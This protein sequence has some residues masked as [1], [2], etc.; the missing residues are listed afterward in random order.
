M[1]V[2]EP[3]YNQRGL[4]SSE[5]LVL[6]AQKTSSGYSVPAGAQRTHAIQEVRYNPKGQK[7]YQELGNGTITCYDYDLPTFRLRQICTRR[8]SYKYNC[9]QHHSGLKNPDILQR[10]N[11]TYDPVGNITEIYDEAYEPVYF[12]NQQVEQ[13]SRYEYDA[14]YR[15]VRAAGR[16]DGAAQGAPGQFEPPLHSVDLPVVTPGALRNY[17]EEYE[18]D[19]VGNIQNLRHSAGPN[20]SFTRY[21]AYAASSN[22]LERTWEGNKN[23][24]NSG[25]THKVTYYYDTHGNMLN[26][27]NLAPADNLRWDY[28][29]ILRALPLPASDW[30]Y[31]NYDSGK[32]RSRK[33]LKRQN[34][35]VA[36][37]IYLGGFELYRKTDALGSVVEEIETHHLFEGD[38]R[39]LLVEEVLRTDNP[40]LPTGP[41]YRYQYSNHLGSAYVELNEQMKIITFEEYHPYGTSAYQAKNSQVKTL[42]KRY[43]YTGKEGDDGTGFYYYGARYYA[44]WLGR[45]ISPDPTGIKA[46]INPLTFN[47]SNPVRYF[48]PT[49]M[50]NVEVT[51][52]SFRGQAGVQNADALIQQVFQTG[53]APKGGTT[54]PQTLDNLLESIKNT[55]R[56]SG[57][58]Q[59]SLSPDVAIGFASKGGTKGGVVFEI[60]PRPDSVNVNTSPI[61]GVNPYPDQYIVAHPGGIE[62]GQVVRAYKVRAHKLAKGR[63]NILITE[64]TE[65]PNSILRTSSLPPA[66]PARSAPNSE[67]ILAAPGAPGVPHSQSGGVTR[68][69]NTVTS[70]IE[71]AANAF[72]PVAAET[73][74]VSKLTRFKAAAGSLLRSTASVASEGAEIVGK[75]AFVVG[76]YNE[77]ATTYKSVPGTWFDKGVAA[78]FTF[79]VPGLGGGIVDDATVALTGGVMIGPQGESYDQHGSGMAQHMLGE[80]QR[81]L[82]NWL[83]Q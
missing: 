30:A 3:T 57:F 58:V 62:P 70:T 8:P 2:Y 27:E 20:G 74:E 78:T 16:E 25:A 33:R 4:L 39:V 80:M 22:R 1:A 64:I 13:R 76:A 63:K 10:L 14:L 46:G 69:A 48:D 21:Y 65:N 9:L 15:L 83:V 53:I 44:S 82:H 66:T 81:S 79:I 55:Y 11:Y 42:P 45:W 73:M 47:K 31:Y 59:S 37:R 28:R 5:D 7:E 60:L 56:N 12:Q 6:R 61:A 34:G 49:G 38:Q 19:P 52:P 24:N 36:D 68:T 51:L 18:Y 41:L 17:T 72:E 54:A 26:L 40:R 75:A 23:W 50:A 77:A 67:S 32:Q 29:D 71:K 43:R 35:A